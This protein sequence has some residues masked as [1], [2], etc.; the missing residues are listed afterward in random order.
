MPKKNILI[1]VIIII[2]IAMVAY[3]AFISS[4]SFF[5]SPSAGPS[6]EETEMPEEVPA[7]QILSEEETEPEVQKFQEIEYK[8]VNQG[9]ITETSEGV[10]SEKKM[11]YDVLTGKISEEKAKALAEK[12]VGDIISG[13]SEIDS[14][15]LNFF[16]NEDSIEEMKIDV[17]IVNWLPNEISV[18]MVEN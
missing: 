1:T 14:I 6:G 9:Q 16:E 10:V 13:D 12:I 3:F 2:V 15:I 18:I 11:I 7:E 5:I 8:I 4:K 17:A